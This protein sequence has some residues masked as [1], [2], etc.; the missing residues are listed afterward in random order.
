MFIFRR[1][2]VFD[3]T[4]ELYTIFEDLLHSFKVTNQGFSL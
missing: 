1:L 2:H 3:A 4:F